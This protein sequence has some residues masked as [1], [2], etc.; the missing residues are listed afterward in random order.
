MALILFCFFQKVVRRMP[1][2]DVVIFDIDKSEFHSPFSDMEVFPREVV[3]RY[4]YCS[5]CAG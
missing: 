1:L 5:Y 2:D 4:V 3:G